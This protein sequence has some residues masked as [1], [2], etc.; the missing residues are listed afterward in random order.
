MGTLFVNALVYPN[1]KENFPP[2]SV[3]SVTMT[4]YSQSHKEQVTRSP[5]TD[6]VAPRQS[7]GLCI[8]EL[9][10]RTTGGDRGH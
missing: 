9:G 3:C 6:G 4:P 8:M 10:Y 7:P 5:E 2:N 1:K